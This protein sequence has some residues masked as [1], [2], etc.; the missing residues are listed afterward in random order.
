MS[1]PAPLIVAA[2]LL[3]WHHIPYVPI[4]VAL[5]IVLSGIVAI[6]RYRRTR[7]RPVHDEGNESKTMPGPQRSR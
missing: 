4:V 1:S 3:P 5:L 6:V 7:R 2:G